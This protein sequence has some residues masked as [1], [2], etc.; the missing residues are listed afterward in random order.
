M[1]LRDHRHVTRAR[2][3]IGP[4][5]LEPSERCSS[6]FSPNNTATPTATHFGARTISIA[7]ADRYGGPTPTR[8]PPHGD[9][10]RVRPEWP[11]APLAPPTPK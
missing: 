11:M 2:I 10:W 4:Q 7:T 9:V 3:S 5:P 8:T 1:T 6:V